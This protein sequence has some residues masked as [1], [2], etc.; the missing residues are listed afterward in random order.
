M[1]SIKRNQV[2]FLKA[3][4]V[5]PSIHAHSPKRKNLF[6]ENLWNNF[7]YSSDEIRLMKQVKG[8]LNNN[9]FEI[10]KHK[11]HSRNTLKHKD[12]K[13]G[14]QSINNMK[15]KTS[16]PDQNFAMILPKK[17]EYLMEKMERKEK[18]KDSSS[19]AS[20]ASPNSTPSVFINYLINVFAC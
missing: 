1:T 9:T 19:S 5:F 7:S 20:S 6:T 18:H 3:F 12:F 15:Y 2:E 8:I 14:I 16:S 4:D 13:Q 11:L 17:P 10:V